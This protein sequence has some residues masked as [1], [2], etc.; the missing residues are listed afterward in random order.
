MEPSESHR[1]QADLTQTHVAKDVPS[2]DSTSVVRSADTLDQAGASSQAEAMPRRLGAYVLVRRLGEGGMGEVFEARRSKSQDRVALKRLPLS[3]SGKMLQYFKR[4]F[5]SLANVH[6]PNLV[7]MHTLECD[8]DQWFLTMDLID[9]GVDFLSY[10][11]P[12]GNLDEGRLRAKLRELASAIAA[13]HARGII[14]RDLKPGNVMVDLEGRL[15]VLDFGL[16]LETTSRVELETG[17]VI[18]GTPA[19]MSP[20]QVDGD[21]VTAACDW[22][23]LGTMLYQAVSGKLPFS[24]NSVIRILHEK[25]VHEAP[26]LD[27]DCPKDL[28]ELATGLLRRDP[29]ERPS[30]DELLQTLAIQPPQKPAEATI[31][32]IGRN[33]QLQELADAF[34]D[35]RRQRKAKLI[36]VTR[37]SGEGKSSLVEVFLQSIESEPDVTVFSGRCYDRESVPFKAVDSV[38]DGLCQHL[39]N[40]DPLVATRMLPDDIGMLVQL[41]PVLSRAKV[42]E[43]TLSLHGRPGQLDARQVRSRAFAPCDSC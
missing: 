23:A 30:S 12:N 16:V 20:Q 2:K 1:N 8:G 27:D 13:L 43:D 26:P 5:R 42:V 4:E 32:L 10:V 33:R 35:C 39:R 18:R 22:Y 24:N 40:L 15:V 21:T 41:F 11:R 37:K 38:I 31:N 6:H 36:N 9:G 29:R 34:D 19:Y 7:G 14:H 3:T 28:R 17:G 25:R